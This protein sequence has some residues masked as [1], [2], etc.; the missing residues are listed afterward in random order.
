MKTK[1]LLIILM[2]VGGILLI[3][4]IGMQV[5]NEV[6]WSSSDF[7]IMGI[8]LFLTG[9]A[10]NFAL[11]KFKT[12]KSRIIACAVILFILFVIWAELAVGIFG[13][14]FAGS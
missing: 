10:I 6:N 1:N 14:P 12:L 7:V 4:F 13:S 8:L 2:V 3:P 11:S 5:S 9:L